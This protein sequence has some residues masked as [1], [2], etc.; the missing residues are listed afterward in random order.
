MAQATFVHDG[1]S[2]DYTPGSA[3][4]AGEVIVLNGIAFVAH[5]AIASGDRGT[6]VASGVFDFTKQSGV[7]FSVGDA[8]Y[9]DDS[10]NYAN[11]TTT[12][13][14]LG[15]AVAAA[16]SGDATVRV[17]LDALANVLGVG[18]LSNIG[19][20]A[21]GLPMLI[22]KLA[23]AAGAGDV[24]VLAS[25]PRKLRVVDAWLVA[26]DTNA[27]NVKLHSGTAGTDD[28][29]NA[30]AKGTTANAIVRWT[31]IIE[32]KQEVAAAGA[33][34][35]NFSAAGSVEAYVLAIPVA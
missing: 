34:K 22:R 12:G 31:Q 7:T 10:N 16:A 15:I 11:K 30:V 19:D 35:I 14:Y 1:G 4:A 32:A 25:A 13:A 24:T 6:L 33:I 27:A 9:W 18:S 29:T 17:R 5:G 21:V 3:V 28:I 2:I 8:V 26:R 20:G 23:T